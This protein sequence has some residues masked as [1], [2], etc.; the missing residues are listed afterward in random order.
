[1]LTSGGSASAGSVSGTTNTATPLSTTSASFAP[2]TKR[3][4]TLATV[5]LGQVPS[6]CR[7]YFLTGLHLLLSLESI[8]RRSLLLWR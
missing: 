3:A 8:K 5:S 2:G 4:R 1:M 6:V 7:R